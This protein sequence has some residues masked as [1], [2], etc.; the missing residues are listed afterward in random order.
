MTS[1]I[2]PEFARRY[3]ELAIIFDNLHSMHDVISDILASDKV[4]RDRKRAEILLAAV[5]Y[6]DDTTEVMTVEGWRRMS[7]M[8]G[9]HNMGGAAVGF[10]DSLPTP[11]VPRGYVM[12]HDLEGNMIGEAHAGHAPADP[13]AGHVAP[14]ARP[15]T[16][17]HAGHAMGADASDTASVASFVRA[18]HAALDRGDSTGVLSRLAEDALVQVDGSAERKASYGRTRLTDDVALAVAVP[19]QRS[20][21]TVRVEGDLAWVTSAMR[22]VGTFRGRTVAQRGEELLVLR[23][24]AQGWSIVSVHRSARPDAPGGA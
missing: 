19:A 24:S 12:R 18:F 10:V 22:Q 4:P 11:T 9:L 1:A 21:Y 23:R 2:A 14:A 3:P 13:H 20:A 6:R 16:D 5:R 7:A 17:A 8:M 15:A